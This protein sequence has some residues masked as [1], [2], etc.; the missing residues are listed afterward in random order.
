MEFLICKSLRSAGIFLLLCLFCLRQLRSG[1]LHRLQPQF[2]CQSPNPQGDGIGRW[3]I[4]KLTG[5]WEWNPHGGIITLLKGPTEV[6]SCFHHSEG[7]VTWQQSV[8]QK[9]DPHQSWNLWAPSFCIFPTSRKRTCV[10]SKPPSLCRFC[11][12]NLQGPARRAD[13]QFFASLTL[14]LFDFAFS[15]LFLLLPQG[16]SVI[17]FPSLSLLLLPDLSSPSLPLLLLLIVHYLFKEHTE[18]MCV[19]I[20]WNPDQKRN[21]FQPQMSLLLCL[22]LPSLSLSLSLHSLFP[23]FLHFRGRYF[24]NSAYH[25]EQQLHCYL[26]HSH[27]ASWAE[28]P[29]NRRGTA[30]LNHSFCRWKTPYFLRIKMFFQTPHNR[31][32]EILEFW[33]QTWFLL[34]NDYVL[35]VSEPLENCSTT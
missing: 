2:I 32:W 23:S 4:C 5:T 17:L 28:T 27:L 20:R 9:V 12:S 10:V 7:T 14:F 6:S 26:L 34:W 1:S 3:G 31:W 15:P 11:Y 29:S 33:L 16:F 30:E 8:T 24:T 18:T 13:S 35:L 19:R 21:T 22:S 25:G